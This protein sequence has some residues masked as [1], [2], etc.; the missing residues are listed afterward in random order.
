MDLDI[1][2]KLASFEKKF[3]EMEKRIDRLETELYQNLDN[4]EEDY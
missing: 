3:K 2:V 4:L 1:E